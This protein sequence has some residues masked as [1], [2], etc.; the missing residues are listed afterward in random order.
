MA[1]AD[2]LTLDTTYTIQLLNR[3]GSWSWYSQVEYTDEVDAH[4]LGRR[5]YGGEVAY[6][7]VT[8]TRHVGE[9]VGAR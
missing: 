6:R 9:P 5:M 8:I 4:D 2:M 3:D 1:Q 7:V